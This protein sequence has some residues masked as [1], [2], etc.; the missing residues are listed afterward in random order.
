M[1]KR[2]IGLKVVGL[3]VEYNP[4]HNG[5]VYHYQEALKETN[6]DAVVVIMSGHFLQRGEPALVNKWTRTEMALHMGA[7][8]VIELPYAYSTQ[9]AKYFAHGAVSLLHHLHFVTHL[10]FGSESGDLKSLQALAAHLTNEP[11]SFKNSIKQIMSSGQSYPKAYAQVLEQFILE[12]H[13]DQSLINQPNNILGLH[14]LIALNQLQSN[15]IP[16]TIKREKAAYHEQHF[17][18][19]QIAS[20]TSIRKAIFSQKTPSWTEIASYVPSYT[21]DF[22]QREQKAGRL[23]S[24]ENYFSFIRYTILSHSN[25]QLEQIYEMEE[26]IENR[27]KKVG[28]TARS[29]EELTQQVKSKRYTL[30]RIQRLLLHSY[31]Q[32]TKKEASGLLKEGPSYL[33]LLGYSKLGRELLNKHKKKI[34]LPLLSNIRKEHPAMLDWDMKAAQLYTLGYSHPPAEQAITAQEDLKKELKQP[35]IYFVGRP[36]K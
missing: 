33:R 12:H 29:F 18:H 34:E 24:W 4:L 36:S 2:C 22:L 16:T 15:I 23:V 35:P 3:I 28:L 25:T 9:Q 32:F 14:Y 10:C 21:V 6:A 11:S 31:T 5:H 1:R 20:A 19:H 17:N 26:G 27:L 30:N 7:D 13:L 8:L